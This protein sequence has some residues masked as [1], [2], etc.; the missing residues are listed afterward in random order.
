MNI[1]RIG[2]LLGKELSHGTRNFIFMFA[3]VIPIVVSLVVA[4]VFGRLL[5]S[6]PRLGIIDE[7]QSELTPLFLSQD[8]L[9]TR[10]YTSADM[11]RRDVENGVVEAGVIIP[12]GFDAAVQDGTNT[13]LTLYFWG[14]GL[15]T[16]RATLITSLAKNVV[17]VSGRDVPVTVEPVTL[18]EGE[19]VSWSERL[20][21]LLVLMTIILGGTLVP[22]VSLVDEK[23]KRTLQAL[24]ITPTSLGEVLMS[25]ALLGVGISL[26]MGI[27]IL[28]LNQAFGTQPLLLIFVLGLGAIAAAEFGIILGTFTKDING[29]FTVVKS[30]SILLYAP[31]L[32]NMIPQLPQWL[33][34]VFPTYY[35]IG[36]IQDIAL[37]GAGWNEIGGQV[38]ILI[39]L[40]LVLLAGLAIAVQ[41]K[42]RQAAFAV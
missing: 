31:A 5:S 37:N 30:M 26:V 40:I 33:A 15:I 9:D 42:Q 27:V 41:R 14:E 16:D 8:Y 24:T 18:G 4:L 17:T 6:T 12:P 1:R 22:A 21:P 28:T 25:K 39:G 34:Q 38:A 20:L 3:T 19:I 35:I 13:D 29:L 10:I 11:L 7:G 2:V 36:P 32:I 23:Q